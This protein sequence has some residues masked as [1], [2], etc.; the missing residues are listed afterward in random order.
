MALRRAYDLSAEGALDVAEI[1][2]T[3]KQEEVRSFLE[4]DGRKSMF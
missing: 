4:M 2:S 3:F 1:T